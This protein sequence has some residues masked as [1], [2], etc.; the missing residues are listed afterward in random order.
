MAM[1]IKKAS[2]YSEFNLTI[3]SYMEKIENGDIT[4]DIDIQRPYVQKDTE[5]KS[6]LI[7][8][9]IINDIIPPFIF[10]KVDDIYE[11]MDCKQRSLT[12]QKFLNNEFALK[13]VMLIEV[14]NDNGE[15][16]ELDIND[17]KF[18]ELPEYIQNAI[19]DCNIK[20]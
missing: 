1:R 13:G 5:Q 11:A 7:Q 4:F 8:S 14:I 19:K 10:N 2:E 16:E 6:L 9:L 18:S 17:L 20:I 15:L 3:R 12:I